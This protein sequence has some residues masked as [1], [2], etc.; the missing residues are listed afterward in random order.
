MGFTIF[1]PVF[2]FS[3]GIVSI[4]T[5]A[6]CF[7]FSRGSRAS[8]VG[9]TFDSNRSRSTSPFSAKQQQHQQPPRSPEVTI[10]ATSVS[11]SNGSSPANP[12]SRGMTRSTSSGAAFTS[13]GSSTTMPPATTSHSNGL[14]AD[15][16][17]DSTNAVVA[18]VPA[19]V[20]SEESNKTGLVKVRKKCIFFC[21]KSW[22]H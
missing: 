3:N 7:F 14:H 13:N 20:V 22:Q 18:A 12:E 21:C 19:E 6:F 4:I 1:C 17:G 5:N 2:F 16:N 11:P 9:R 10:A 8:S 15:K